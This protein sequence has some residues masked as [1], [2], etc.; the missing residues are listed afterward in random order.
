MQ[1]GDIH[2]NMSGWKR[3]RETREQQW[4]W[5]DNVSLINTT[6]SIEEM[7]GIDI[8]GQFSEGRVVD[9]ARWRCLKVGKDVGVVRKLKVLLKS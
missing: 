4:S 5:R 9:E 6:V 2:N 7:E 3:R 1:F 8:M